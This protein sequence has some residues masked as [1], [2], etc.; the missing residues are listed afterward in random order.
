[1]IRSAPRRDN[2]LFTVSTDG[3]RTE[4]LIRLLGSDRF[5]P[6]RS[7]I[8]YVQYKFQAEALA[9]QLAVSACACLRV[10]CTE[11]PLG[12]VSPH[13][14]VRLQSH[15]HAARAYHAGLPAKTRRAAQDQ[16]MKGRLRIIVATV[17]FG[18]GLDKADVRAVIHYSL[19][20]TLENYVQEV[21]RAGRD[22]EPAFCHAF[23]R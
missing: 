20:Q 11:V 21:G 9:Q 16:F 10:H 19:P 1:M 18:M 7:I 14:P 4:A 3:D 2:L 22:G 17:A 12:L 23:F 8:V 13:S 6:L 5:K 15:G